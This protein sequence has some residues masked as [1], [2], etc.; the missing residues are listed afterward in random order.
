MANKVA[1][2]EVKVEG[3]VVTMT[4]PTLG[5]SLSIDVSEL[6]DEMYQQAAIHGIKQVSVDTGA[7][8]SAAE[9]YAMLSRRYEAIAVNE[10]NLSGERDTTGEVVEAMVAVLKGKHTVDELMLAVERKPEQVK[11][12]RADPRVKLF[13]AKKR[14]AKAREAA[15]GVTDEIVVEGLEESD[16]EEAAE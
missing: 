11:A 14:E 3:T 13:L 8:K 2:Q 4:Y 15:K 1:K 10:W 9:A 7:G 5:K 6:S 12:W 16:E